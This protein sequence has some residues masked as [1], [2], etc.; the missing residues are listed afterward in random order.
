ML[1]TDRLETD[2]NRSLRNTNREM[3]EKWNSVEYPPAKRPN[4][5]ERAPC[6][7]YIGY[8]KLWDI[9]PTA[10]PTANPD[11]L[12]DVTWREV[13]WRDVT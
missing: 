4:F 8:C 12:P 6:E 13:T 10:I 7:N 5:G 1:C 11:T 9:I 2:K 3:N